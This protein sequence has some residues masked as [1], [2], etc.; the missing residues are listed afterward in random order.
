MQQQAA[1]IVEAI[2]WMVLLSN[3]R[4][5][6][7]SIAMFFKRRS[8]PPHRWTKNWSGYR[9]ICRAAFTAGT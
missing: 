8:F 5:C 2:A 6:R 3:A 9:V 7:K 1:R 4:I